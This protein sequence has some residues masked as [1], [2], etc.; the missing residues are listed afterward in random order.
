MDSNT[1]GGISAEDR[2][3]E[4]LTDLMILLH[5]ICTEAI[6]KGYK[7]LDIALVELCQKYIENQKPKKAIEDFIIY[8]SKYWDQMYDH[9]VEF[10]RKNI[11]DVFSGLP[12]P[13]PT[14]K[15]KM[16]EVVYS[17]YSN[18][19]DEEEVWEY[20]DILTKISINY[21]FDNP[22]NYAMINYKLN[23]KKMKQIELE[24]EARKRGI[25]RTL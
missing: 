24:K 3:H 20:I 10:F 2:F 15:F 9:C 18:P 21:L 16:F 7:N 23:D 17:D 22:D 13:V 8:S 19:D 14:D 1:L 25:N 11:G 12:F 5:A 6:E 4:T